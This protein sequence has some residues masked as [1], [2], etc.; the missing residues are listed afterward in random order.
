MKFEVQP[1]GY[2]HDPDVPD[3]EMGKE[4]IRLTVTEVVCS[5]DH[6][7]ELRFCANAL[8]PAEV[9]WRYHS[10]GEALV[11]VVNDVDQHDGFAVRTYNS[12]IRF[13]QDLT[14]N[15]KSPPALPLPP[16]GSLK[17]NDFQ[18]AFVNGVVSF[19]AAPP[20]HRPSVFLYLVLENYVSN[21]V[22]LDLVDRRAVPF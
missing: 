10:L 14:I 1:F 6:Q 11:L 20:V 17:A 13:E 12:F 8:F 22:G 4:S 21:V 5:E 18:G 19:Q 2:S 9:G 15:L 16:R 7:V 3:V